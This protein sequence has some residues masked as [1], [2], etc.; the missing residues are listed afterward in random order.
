LVYGVVGVDFPA[1]PSEVMILADGNANPVWIAAD[2]IAQAEHDPLASV[3]LVTTSAHLAEEVREELD[4]QVEDATRAVIIKRALKRGAILIASS[5]REGINF[6]NDYAPEHLEIMTSNPLAV[7]DKVVNAGSVFLGDYAPVS[8]GDYCVGPSH[9]LPTNGFA[10]ARGGLG[11][12]DFIK[13]QSY[14]SL[15]KKG[16][17]RLKETAETLARVEGLDAHAKAIEVRFQ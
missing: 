5:P 3:I 10:R 2:L 13:M 6:I 11:V 17:E 4:K 15:T 8:V 9:V 16:L 7:L 12:G 14:Q 1:G